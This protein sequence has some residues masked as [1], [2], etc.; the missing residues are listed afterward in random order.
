MVHHG[1]II[2]VCGDDGHLRS[3]DGGTT[4]TT[5]TTQPLQTGQ[6]SIAASP[7]ESY[8]LFAVVGLSIFESDNG[9]QSWPVSYAN[10]RAQGRI[11]FLATNKRSGANYDLWFGDVQLHRGTCTT[12][13]PAAAGGAQR[14]N[15]STAWA[16]PF[17]RSVGA[18]DDSGD[19]AFAPGA[20]ANACPAYF[21]SDGGVFRNTLTASPGCHTPA[22]TQPT[23]TPHALWNYSFAGVS[24]PGPVTEHLYLGNQD[25]GTFGTLNGGA[26]TVT[27]NSQLCCDGFDANG[28]GTRALTTTCCCVAPGCVSATGRQTRLW[29]SSP[30]LAG[31]ATEI[32]TYPTGNM[33]QFEQLEAIVN[34]SAN[35]YAIATTSGVF[36]TPNIGASPIAWTQLGAASSPASPCGLTFATTAGTPTFFVKNGGCDGDAPGPLFSYQ[37]TAAGGTWQ[38][39]PV[40]GLGGFGIFAVDPND[41]RRLIASHLGAVTGPQMVLT[42]N[43]GA[44]WNVLSA[45]DTLMTGAGAFNYANQTGPTAFAAFNGYPQPT[46]VAFDPS[47]PDLVVAGGADSGVFISTNGGTRYQLV[48]DPIS[49]GTSGRPHIPR[50]YYAHFDHDPPG[51]DINLF[52]GTRGRGAW[53][54]TFKKVLMPEIQVPSPPTFAPACPRAKQPGTLNV[55]NTS[56]GDLIVTS[57]GSSNPEFAITSPSAGFPVT[58]SHDF[59]FPFEVTFTP[60]A[61]GSRTTDITINSNDPSFPLLHVA[62]SATANQPAIA[63]L[64]ANTG[65]FGTV[66]PANFRD[67]DLTVQNNGLCSLVVSGV[68]SSSSDFKTATTV[69]FPLTIAPGTS[70][71]VPIRFEPATPGA[72]SATLA[73]NS[74]DPAKPSASVPVKG[75]GG[76]PVIATVI[77][78]NGDFG[79]VCVGDF[80]DLP[81]TIQNSGTC[82]LKVTGISSSSPEFEMPGVLSYPLVVAPG[83]SIQVPVRYRPTSAGI[84]SAT[85]T[86]ASDDPVAASK[87]VAVKATT[88]P[89]YI[90]HPPTFAVV[91]ANIGPTFGPSRTGDYSF[92]GYGRVLHPIGPRKNYAIQ[93][94]GEY[95][96]YPRRQEGQFDAGVL[97]RFGL[98]QAGAFADF[99]YAQFNAVQNGSTLGQAAL[100][101]D[102]L[103]LPHAR[104][105]IFGT[106]GFRDYGVIDRFLVPGGT[107]ETYLR[108]VDQFG[109]SGQVQLPHRTYLE[110]TLEWLHRYAPGLDDRP[111]AMLRLVHQWHQVGFTVEGDFNETFVGRH[112]SGRV[113]F[114][115]QLGHWPRPSD[116][117]NKRNPLGTEV[118]RVHYELLQRVR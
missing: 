21:A 28:D 57:I 54:L 105:G 1:G 93:G 97:S 73:V 29:V 102:F 19:I 77:A 12:P 59:C 45:L 69:S 48:T 108:I 81:L 65:D 116:M 114:G 8:V 103:F 74:N 110:G 9:G 52:L 15:A 46:L 96:Y 104:F 80:R 78:D 85:I 50:P 72:K 62:A 17:T 30:G 82:P 35:A 60:I 7:D 71:E 13:S 37:G 20:V 26:G 91:G 63:T 18:H 111:G 100:T 61:F 94:Q 56:A 66:C 101:L 49:P 92:S 106:K 38:Q 40:P 112:D 6:C 44:S 89:D 47:D 70:L 88:P 16:G 117:R 33:R 86:I 51:G 113:V 79:S 67:L 99:K 24:Q 68:T 3:T 31:S 2:D 14:C 22:W 95:L 98:V 42:R 27:W 5:A 36:I 34:Y 53:R 64:I 32:G 4:W 90:C 39:V 43:G 11:P 10:P 25:N 115:V 75:V 109:G 41:P 107:R 55:C 118:P 84:K 23:V 87:I 83:T 76:Q 58:I